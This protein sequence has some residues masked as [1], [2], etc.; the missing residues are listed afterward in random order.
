MTTSAMISLLLVLTASC[1]VVD[2]FTVNYRRHQRKSRADAHIENF[3]R[4]SSLAFIASSLSVTALSSPALAEPQELR[5]LGTTAPPPEGETPF[6]TLPSGVRT[7]DFKDGSGETVS[8]GS[9]VSIQCSGRLLNLNGVAF[10]NTKN[11]NVDGFG[12]TPLTFKMGSGVALPGLEEGIV[13]MKKGSIRRIIVPSE[14]G[15]SSFPGLEPKPTNT[16]DQKALD[17]V[18]M[19]PRRDATLLFDVKLEKLK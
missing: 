15:Y 11:N 7:K 1:F 4:R 13:G 9:T 10:Y 3:D 2:G 19:N 16:I 12:P 14:L 18:V 17:S 5:A 8:V 6:S